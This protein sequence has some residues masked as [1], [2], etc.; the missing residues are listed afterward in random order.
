M[1]DNYFD[2]LGISRDA[3]TAEVK[4]A[5]R[6]LAQQYHPDHEGG[7]SRRFR[8]VQ[9]AYNVLADPE[10]RREHRRRCRETGG[11]RVPVR[12]V[13]RPSAEREERARASRAEPIR[14][15]DRGADHI[16][17]GWRRREYTKHRPGF[18]HPSEIEEL[19]DRLLRDLFTW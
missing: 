15:R 9:E 6:K 18:H 10:Q 19:F 2:I 3:D 16:A 5:Y 1:A 7:D 8:D 12:V 14:P 13:R 4:N 17:P 11:E